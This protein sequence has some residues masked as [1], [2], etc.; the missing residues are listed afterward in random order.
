MI[1]I[2]IYIS[3]KHACTI[4]DCNSYVAS[5]RDV[6]SKVK[7]RIDRRMCVCARMC[8]F[9]P[10]EECQHVWLSWSRHTGKQLAHK[11]NTTDGRCASFKKLYILRNEN[12]TTRLTYPVYKVTGLKYSYYIMIQ[13]KR[14][15]GKEIVFFSV[16][17]FSKKKCRH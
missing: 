14:L 13:N 5:A 6:S 2:Y 10:S 15:Y 17:R 11:T 9:L 16:Y 3:T 4:R 1:Y 8:P 7:L 12:V